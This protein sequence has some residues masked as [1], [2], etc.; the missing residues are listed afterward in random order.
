MGRKLMRVPLDFDY[1]IGKVWYGYFFVLSFCQDNCDECK[2]YAEIKKIPINSY[3]CP[4]FE[5][6][7]NIHLDVE[8]S[9]GEGYQLW[10]T[11]T[12]GSPS[13]PVFESLEALCEWCEENATTFGDF[14]ATKEE[15]RNL[16]SADLF[17]VE[18]GN[19]GFI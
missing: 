17:I 6:F 12:E 9:E 3:G 4:D 14:T 10:E 5:A 1:P 8:P 15:W 13:S 19:I 16:L 18:K 7:Y 11:T 2:K